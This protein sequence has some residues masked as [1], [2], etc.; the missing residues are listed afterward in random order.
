MNEEKCC[1]CKHWQKDCEILNFVI[2]WN[3]KDYCSRWQPKPISEVEKITKDLENLKTMVGDRYTD[4]IA[5][6]ILAN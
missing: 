4:S 1:D 6:Y 5:K 2:G 3:E